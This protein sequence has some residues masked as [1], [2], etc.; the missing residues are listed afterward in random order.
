MDSQEA[1]IMTSSKEEEEEGHCQYAL[2]L[3]TA[4][5][6][7]MVLKGAIE[8]DVLEIIDRAGPGALFSPS[9][10]ASHINNPDAPLMLDRIL[11]LLA[12]HSVLTCSLVNHQRLYGL[13]PVSKYFLRNQNGVSFSSLIDVIQDKVIMDMWYHLK[14]AVVEGGLPFNRAYGMNASE[15]VGKD[16]RLG[17]IFMNFMTD[18]N[19]MFMNKILETYTGFEGLKSMVDVGGG[20]G[21]ILNRII[22]KYP[23]INGVNFDLGS[24]ITKAPSYPG[25]ENVVGD[26]FV[27]IP[28]GDAIFM[29]WILHSWDD[30]NCLKILKNCYE[31]LP[32]DGK[33]I[34]VDVVIPEVPETNLEVKSIF[35]FDLYLMNMNPGGKE[36]TEREFSCLAKEAGFSGIRVACSVY[37]FSLMEFYKEL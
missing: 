9:E 30:E 37:N 36:R 21:A 34:V 3:A 33:V 25:I 22:S 8:L 7:P 27:N 17:G 1:N 18:Y 10:I 28:K 26:M 12:S 4:S 19:T 16:S 6:F 32:N 35:Q 15:Y 24:V 2:Q 14:D 5:I 29:K 11:R 13:A 23:A 31:A 20:N